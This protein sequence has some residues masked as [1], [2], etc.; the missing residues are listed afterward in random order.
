VAFTRAARCFAV[1][2]VVVEDADDPDE[3]DDL[4]PVPGSPDPAGEAGAGFGA[5][6]GVGFGVGFGDAA[7]G[8]TGAVPG[9]A[10]A[11]LFCQRQPMNPP[12]GT[13]SEPIPTLA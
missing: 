3:P 7:I 1:G 4:A 2:V 13:F 8:D 12:A 9:L 6:F 10:R 11:L 5:G